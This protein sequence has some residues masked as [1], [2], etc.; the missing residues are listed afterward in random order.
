LLIVVP[1]YLAILLLPL[2]V[3]SRWGSGAKDLVAA[4]DKAAAGHAAAVETS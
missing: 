1:L 4:M 3:G 2:R